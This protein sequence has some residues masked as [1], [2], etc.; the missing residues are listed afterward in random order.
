MTLKEIQSIE[1]DDKGFVI[2]T[3]GSNT[4]KFV[5]EILV[6]RA[7]DNGGTI[8]P[9]S[10][11]DAVLKKGKKGSRIICTHPELPT[12]VFPSITAARVEFGICN[13]TVDKLLLMTG[14]RTLK[15][16]TFNKI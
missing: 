13:R 12:K 9:F 3:T 10:N 6:K 2:I 15:G 5:K 14:Y 8:N 11:A 7:V 1:P 4:A 16:Y